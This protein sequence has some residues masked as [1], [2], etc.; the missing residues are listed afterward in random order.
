MIHQNNTLNSSKIMY[1]T[2]KNQIIEEFEKIKK[3][4]IKK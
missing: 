2:Q 3:E 1:I 4:V